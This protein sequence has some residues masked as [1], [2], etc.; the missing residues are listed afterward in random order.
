M[1]DPRRRWPAERALKVSARITNLREGKT[2]I[3]ARSPGSLDKCRQQWFVVPTFRAVQLQLGRLGWLV[4]RLIQRGREGFS[5]LEGLE[6][7]AWVFAAIA[8]R[9]HQPMVDGQRD[10]MTRILASFVKN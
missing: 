8:V 2:E 4:F 1:Q 3:S 7:F 6:D 9:T 10:E 5:L